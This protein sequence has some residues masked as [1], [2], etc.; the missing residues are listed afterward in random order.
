M[1]FSIQF[2]VKRNGRG[3][4]V[5]RGMDEQAYSSEPPVGWI[6]TAAIPRA[7]DGTPFMQVYYVAMSDQNNAR[8]AVR[9]IVAVAA[10]DAEVIAHQ[11]IS[12]TLMS[13]LSLKSGDIAQ[14]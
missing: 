10:P 5:S 1:A 7:G 3:K 11:P 12:K 4:G 14:W 9:S 13:S 6:V 2:P 8:E